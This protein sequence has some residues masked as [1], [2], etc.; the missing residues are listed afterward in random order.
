MLRK[1]VAADK[2]SGGTFSEASLVIAKI[3]VFASLTCLPPMILFSS[4]ELTPKLEQYA[5]KN[6]NSFKGKTAKFYRATIPQKAVDIWSQLPP[7][8]S[9]GYTIDWIRGAYYFLAGWLIIATGGALLLGL[10]FLLAKKF[11][12]LLKTSPQILLWTP[13]LAGMAYFALGFYLA[14]G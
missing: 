4:L 12:G 6:P 7:V 9:K 5:Q 2:L 1:V 3:V 8:R 11:S 10:G 14:A 13:L